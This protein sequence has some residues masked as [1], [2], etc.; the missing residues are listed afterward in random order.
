MITLH[1]NAI[2][3]KIFDQYYVKSLKN[4]EKKYKIK[5]GLENSSK[6]IFFYFNKYW[7]SEK[8]FI[9]IILKTDFKITLDT[10]HLGRSGIDI[11]DFF[12][13]N[14][15]KI[16]NIHLSDYKKSILG[17]EHLPLGDGDLPLKEFIKNLFHEK[18]DG[19]VT[20]EIDSDI[21]KINKSIRSFADHTS[22][23][24]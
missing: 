7:W 1:I 24:I 12:Q 14:K 2:G 3:G 5:I 16:I 21:K 11:I 6:N 22:S 15:Q 18:Y 9:N 19:L 20:L 8:E 4:L 10:T 23:R 13:K 17:A